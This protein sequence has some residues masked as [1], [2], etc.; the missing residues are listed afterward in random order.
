MPGAEW[1]HWDPGVVFLQVHQK[2]DVPVG[3][4]ELPVCES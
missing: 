1:S 4:V 2:D 3:E